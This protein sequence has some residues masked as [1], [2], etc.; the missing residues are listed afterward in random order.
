[1]LT[2]IPDTFDALEQTGVNAVDAITDSFANQIGA[3]ADST[4]ATRSWGEVFSRVT[5]GIVADTTRILI[6]LVVV[7]NLLQALGIGRQG[8]QASSGGGG[9][10][11]PLGSGI[12]HS[13]GIV[14]RLPLA[15]RRALRRDEQLAVLRRGEEV[16][17]ADDPRHRHNLGVSPAA[18]SAFIAR[19]PRYH[20][21]GIVGARTPQGS[22]RGGDV[23]VNI[24]N[25]SGTQV[26]AES[27]GARFDGEQYIVS[28]VLR[29][30]QDRGAIG[31]AMELIGGR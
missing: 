15:P 4:R 13:G 9:T 2:S 10:F 28:V 14:G 22:G 17:T 30:I 12:G 21:G 29:D 3:M 24:V 5:S 8:E 26:E 1:M 11:A 25:E 6:R 31:R 16:L 27:A 20:E 7:R 18:L 19:L 23:T